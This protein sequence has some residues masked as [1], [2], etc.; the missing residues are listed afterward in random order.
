MTRLT[1]E[2]VSQ[3]SLPPLSAQCDNGLYAVLEPNPSS[4]ASLVALCAG[5]CA[6]S[7]GRLL[8]DGGSPYDRP[9]IRARIALLGA[10]EALPPASC[11]RHSLEQV[12]GLRETRDTAPALLERWR[13]TR[14]AD[15]A[16]DALRPSELRSL[17]LALALDHA[18]AAL[19]ALH[20]PLSTLL[21]AD[22]VCSQL[23]RA[24]QTGVVI[25]TVARL[26]DAQR[27]G[28]HVVSLRPNGWRE[29][30]LE[31]AGSCALRVRAAEAEQLARALEQQPEV[32][33]VVRVGRRELVV[34]GAVLEALART[35]AQVA[36]S[37]G[38]AIDALREQ[39]DPYLLGA[40]PPLPPLAARMTRDE[41]VP[42][43]H[44]RPIY[45]LGSRS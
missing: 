1:L 28:G 40:L 22:A 31:R 29:L 37:A 23:T 38:L 2:H 35:I 39:A 12:L 5:L 14:L 32:L 25:A 30:T 26:E 11:V 10:E 15:E 8:L 4:A 45:G 7:S 9:A 42:A 3:P 18:G 17:A 27:L 21:D 20:E 44:S 19:L 33:E 43:E 36:R 6:P 41:P 13:L 34:C 16:L 24:A